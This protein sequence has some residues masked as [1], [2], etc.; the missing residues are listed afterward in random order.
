[1]FPVRYEMNF[2][3]L[4]RRNSIFVGINTEVSRVMSKSAYIIENIQPL[5]HKNLFQNSVWRHNRC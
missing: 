4:L 1:V 3:I 5:H 2:Y